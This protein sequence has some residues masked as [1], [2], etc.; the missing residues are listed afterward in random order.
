MFEYMEMI[1]TIIGLV[2]SNIIFIAKMFENKNTIK[3]EQ[4]IGLS[5]LTL[6][7]EAEKFINYSGQEK[8]AYVMTRIKEDLLTKNIK[9]DIS[10]IDQKIEELISLSNVVN[11]KNRNPKILNKLSEGA[12]IDK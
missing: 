5:L 8:K 1:I 10:K 4:N 11:A 9:F 3:F 6:I 7:E 12:N 2:L